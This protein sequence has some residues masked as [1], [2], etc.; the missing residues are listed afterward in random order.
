MLIQ[1]HFFAL[2]W[3]VALDE[4]WRKFCLHYHAPRDVCL[5]RFSVIRIPRIF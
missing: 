3:C 2:A 5:F 4:V 1:P